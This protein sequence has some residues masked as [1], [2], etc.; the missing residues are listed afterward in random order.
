MENGTAGDGD[1]VGVLVLDDHDPSRLGVAVLLRREPWVE[2][3]SLA[4]DR[5]RATELVRRHRPDVAVV[6]ISNVGPFVGLL[7]EALRAPHPELRVLLTARCASVS[8]APLRH[9]QERFLPAGT[10]GHEIVAGV[11]AAARDPR[12]APPAPVSDDPLSVRERE[13]LALLAT[14]ATNREIAAQ[15]HLGPDS[16]KKYAS[17]IYRKLGVRN[18]TEATQFA[19]RR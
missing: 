17:S 3:C 5:R 1:R 13:V 2:R 18:R 7:L 4:A 16:V 14:G 6:D 15:L 8:T 9:V 12:P 10:P 19:G 11:L